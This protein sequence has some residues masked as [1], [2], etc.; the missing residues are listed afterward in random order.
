ML[1]Y[2]HDPFVTLGPWKIHAFP[3]CA[4]A[5]LVTARWIILRGARRSG[6]R[7]DEIAPLYLSV[8][9]AGIV[10]AMIAPFLT[11]GHGLAS[12]GAVGGGLTAAI[13]YC[14]LHR[15]SWTRSAALLDIL[16]FA[17]PFAGAIGRLGCTLAHDHRGLPSESWLAFRFPEG[18]RYDLG[19]IDLLFLSSLCV[20]FVVLDRRQRP[21][22]LFVSV[23]AGFYGAFRIWRETL[24][25]TPHFLPWTVVC[26]LGLAVLMFGTIPMALRRPASDRCRGGERRAIRPDGIVFPENAHE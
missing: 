21:P 6:I 10:G 11:G 16:A 23:G 24:D 7:Y 2:F 4:L 13:G 22:F 18:G 20:L 15:L 5:A 1:P 17:A 26:A 8:I 3:V 19:F 9:V 14:W 25:V 12:I